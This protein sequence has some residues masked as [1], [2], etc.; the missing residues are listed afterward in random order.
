MEQLLDRQE[1]VGQKKEKAGIFVS[2]IFIICFRVENRLYHKIL[3]VP[4]ILRPIMFSCP[5][6]MESV[7]WIWAQNL[8]S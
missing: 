6:F 3:N 5:L 1:V 8:I 4:L 2:F 7:A